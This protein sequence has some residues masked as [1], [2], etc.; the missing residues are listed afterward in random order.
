MTRRKA[1]GLTLLELL[2]TLAISVLVLTIGVNAF[3]TIVAENRMATAVNTLVS[4]LQL[5]R[6]EAIKR[7]QDVTVCVSTNSADTDACEGNASGW[8]VRYA[9]V[10]DQTGTPEV[11]RI[12]DGDFG[13]NVGITVQ[14]NRDAVVYGP[15]G[16]TDTAAA[17][18]EFKFQDSGG[19]A[20]C[21]M[22]KVSAVGYVT[23]KR[24]DDTEETC[25]YE[26]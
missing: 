16:T 12:Q 11:L 13:S 5:A 7:G 17:N 19:S 15:D 4:H 8:V 14:G 9:T 2:V 18:D 23:T 10:A 20:D 25:A 1:R 26:D 24:V 3:S 22:L 6:S 21:R